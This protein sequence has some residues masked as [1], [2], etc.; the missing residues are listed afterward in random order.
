MAIFAALLIMAGCAAPIPYTY[1]A[2]P[3]DPVLVFDSDFDFVTD[4]SV[5]IDSCT[6]F[7]WAGYILNKVPFFS[8]SKAVEEF[9]ISTPADQEVIVH[10]FYRSAGLDPSGYSQCGPLLKTFTPKKGHRY[11]V[12]M[13]E[14]GRRCGLIISDLTDPKSRVQ[15][16]SIKTCGKKQ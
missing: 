12:K 10:A 2:A 3:S 11:L 7:Q 15:S 6:S 16:I 1:N 8:P 4:F 5:S 9:Q 13:L 14:A